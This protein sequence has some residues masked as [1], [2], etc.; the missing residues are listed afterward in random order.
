V[1][2][3]EN[4]WLKWT[5]LDLVSHPAG[6]TPTSAVSL[7]DAIDSM[8]SDDTQSVGAAAF[9]AMLAE[10]QRAAAS[11]EQMAKLRCVSGAG[12]GKT[13]HRTR[14]NCSFQ[15]TMAMWLWWIESNPLRRPSL[16]I[17]GARECAT[18]LLLITI[19]A[20]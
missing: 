20:R 12:E 4:Q 2:N 3:R 5:G 17:Y 7:E 8:D 11:I 10:S 9:E 14:L 18:T 19:E 16:C 15:T 13:R 6:G 1:D